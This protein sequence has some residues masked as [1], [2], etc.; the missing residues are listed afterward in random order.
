MEAS[1]FSGKEKIGLAHYFS[2]A[3]WKVMEVITLT[4]TSKAT[5]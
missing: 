1:D 3:F 5:S 4:S 2:Q